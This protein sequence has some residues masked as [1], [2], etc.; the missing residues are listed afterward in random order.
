MYTITTQIFY[1]GPDAP[2]EELFEFWWSLS[3]VKCV[4]CGYR[5]AVH[6]QRCTHPRLLRA[7][8]LNTG[9]P[10]LL[11]ITNDQV[12]IPVVNAFLSHITAQNLHALCTHNSKMVHHY[13][14][15]IPFRRLQLPVSKG[16]R[17]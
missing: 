10:T 1:E 6:Q 17:G 14:G 13:R 8:G 16:H 2:A 3:C 12:N 4:E 9:I 5:H 7:I 15:P 11:E